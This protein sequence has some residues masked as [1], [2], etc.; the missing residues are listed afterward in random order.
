M[1]LLFGT[2]TAAGSDQAGATELANRYTQAT[3]GSDVAGVRLARLGQLPSE[4][5]V[6][7]P[8]MLGLVVY[9]H[10]GGDINDGSTNAGVTIAGKSLAVFVCMDGTTWAAQYTP[11]S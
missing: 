7:N 4:M 5:Y 8:D 10:V 1:A 9:P 2:A 11:N 6:Y 3:G